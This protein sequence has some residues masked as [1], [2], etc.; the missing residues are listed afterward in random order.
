MTLQIKANNFYRTRGGEIA[1]IA[2]IVPFGFPHPV[3]GVI[4]DSPKNWTLSGSF[5][6]N[7]QNLNDLVEH[8]PDCDSFDWVPKPKIQVEVGKKYVMA[9]GD[10]VGPMEKEQACDSYHF[11]FNGMHWDIEGIRK[12]QSFRN[13]HNIVSEYIEPEPVYE[14]F[15]NAAEFAPHRDKWVMRLDGDGCYRF[16]GYDDT[17]VWSVNGTRYTYKDLFRFRFDDGKPCG[18]VKQ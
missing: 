12:N 18:R 6:L 1:Y 10:V 4:G 13:T 14:P 3:L 2:A 17:G 15:A 16:N 5:N 8:I 11:Y 9:N 7:D